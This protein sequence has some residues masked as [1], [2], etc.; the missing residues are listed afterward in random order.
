MGFVSVMPEELTTSAAS[1]ASL[2]SAMSGASAGAAAPTMGVI[3]P[4]MEETSALLAASF[5]AHGAIYQAAAMMADV[6]H[7]M[8]A[9]NLA[10][11]G[12]SYEAVEVIHATG[13]LL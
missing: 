2:G 6:V 8:A 4:G 13:A 9:M 5:A 12:A 3:P 11:N 7:Q 1:M 10:T